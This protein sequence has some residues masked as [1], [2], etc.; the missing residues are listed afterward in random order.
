MSQYSGCPPILGKENGRCERAPNTVQVHH[1]R[2][3]NVCFTTFFVAEIRRHI[4]LEPRTKRGCGAACGYITSIR[5]SLLTSAFF[6]H[7][8]QFYFKE[9]CHNT[10]APPYLERIMGG[11]ARSSPRGSRVR[12]L[13]LSFP[14]MGGQP[15]YWDIAP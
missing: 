10:P 4:F 8:S 3:R 5:L 2:V 13:P 15:E 11:C 14:G 7:W 1:H 9:L 6:L 12:I